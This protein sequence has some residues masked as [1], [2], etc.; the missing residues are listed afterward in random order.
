MPRSSRHDVLFEPIEIGPQTLRNRFYQV[1]YATGFHSDKPG[2]IAY[3]RGIKAEGGWAAVNTGFASISAH[4]DELPGGGENFWDADDAERFSLMCDEAHRHGALAGIE[5]EHGGGLSMRRESRWAAM[6]PSQ[7]PH[8]W[9]DPALGS[10]KA[11]DQDDIRQVQQ[12]WAAA[13]ERARDVGF[14]IVYVYGGHGML[15]AQ[16][17]SPYYNK[18]TDEYGGSLE[19]RARFWLETID[20]VRD[21]VGD[22]C[23]IAV[24]I[25]IDA[26]GPAGIDADETVRFIRLADDLVDLW[27]INVG[28]ATNFYYDIGASRFFPEG[29]QVEWSKRARE[30]TAKPIVGVSRLTNPDHMAEIIRSGAWDIIGAA[31][32]SIADPFL[33]N[34]IAEGQLDDI[35]ECVGMNYCLAQTHGGHVGCVQNATA[36]EEYRRRWHPERF[37]QAENANNDVLI[38]GAGVAGLECAM[39]LGKRGMRRIHLVD[40]ESDVGGIL[41]WIPELPGLGEWGRIVDYRRIQLEKLRNV[42]VITGTSLSVEQ[43]ADYGA[44]IVVVATG[45]RWA[46]DGMSGVTHTSIV[47]ADPVLPHVLTPE[48]VMCEGKRPPSGTVLVYDCE[49]YFM[50]TALAERLRGDGYDVVYVT[51]LGRVSPYSDGTEEGWLVRR[52][53]HD[54]GVSAYVNTTLERID[55]HHVVARNEFDEPVELGASSVVLVT[56]RVS[57]ERLYC[58]L[59]ARSAELR[60]GGVT[61]LYRIGDCVAPRVLGDIVFDG[62]RL[63][64]EIDS[65]DPAIPRPYV[66]ERQL[67]RTLGELSPQ[68]LSAV[69][70]TTVARESW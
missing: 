21:A 23:A 63:G 46:G 4:S 37:T 60:A 56:Q 49:G 34:K 42:E 6:A 16:F 48:Q 9:A 36:G 33:P 50:G 68:E 12:Q 51:A 28:S 59:R 40:A 70:L 1:P 18:R 57:E 61:G 52:R 64:R 44:E 54:I 43:V 26:L 11:M 15:P 55:P 38:V 27:D 5:L 7:I 13:A 10:P 62:H 24:R 19:N 35:R 25:A 69:P 31:R 41:R 22:A 3:H 66:R 45:A 14:D 39:V 53:L 58:D 47:G 2:S 29:H 67:R 8:E 65:E 30:A 32:P 20:A 17:L